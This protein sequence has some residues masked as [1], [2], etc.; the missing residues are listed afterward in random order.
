MGHKSAY[1]WRIVEVGADVVQ[2]LFASLLYIA[3]TGLVLQRIPAGPTHDAPRCR[4]E[5]IT[6]NELCAI[7]EV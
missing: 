3:D 5:R 7:L 4:R 6:S 1:H 2:R